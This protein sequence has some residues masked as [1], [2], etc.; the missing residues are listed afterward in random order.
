GGNATAPR[1]N[2]FSS[3]RSEPAI[4]PPAVS[5]STSHTPLRRQF[6]TDANQSRAGSVAHRQT[7]R[8]TSRLL[9]A[10]NQALQQTAEGDE[11]LLPSDVDEELLGQ[12]AAAMLG[13]E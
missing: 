6:V 2:P 9:A 8:L 13:L 11:A 4:M 7:D 3:H 10:H 1:G 12:L 5:P